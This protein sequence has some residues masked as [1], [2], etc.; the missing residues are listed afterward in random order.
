MYLKLKYQCKK[1]G[2]I[3]KGAHAFWLLGRRNGRS[4][5]F[6]IETSKKVFSVKLFPIGNKRAQL[7]FTNNES[8]FIRKYFVLIGAFA[9]SAKFSNDSRTKKIPSYNFKKNYKDIWY[10]KEFIP[11]LLIHPCCNDFLYQVSS[12]KYEVINSEEIINGMS[13]LWLSDLL[14][15]IH[16]EHYENTQFNTYQ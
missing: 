1:N 5:D 16:E 4:S 7:F 6:Y 14:R 9:T 3:L 12:N 15:I 11:I 8:Y 13:I 10:I 2:A